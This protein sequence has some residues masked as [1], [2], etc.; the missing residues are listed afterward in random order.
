MKIGRVVVL[1]RCEDEERVREGK[2]G[3]RGWGSIG[4]FSVNGLLDNKGRVGREKEGGED[5]R[6][7]IR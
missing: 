3:V 5:D 2:E 7:R 6:E 4:G 1:T